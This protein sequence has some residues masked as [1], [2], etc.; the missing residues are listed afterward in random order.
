MLSPKG[1]EI[2]HNF[3]ETT[4]VLLAPNQDG[5]KPGQRCNHDTWSLVEF[6]TA[7]PSAWPT[8]LAKSS[9]GI[10]VTW[11]NYRSWDLSIQRRR[12]LTFKLSRI[13]QLRTLMRSVTLWT[14]RQISSVLLVLEI[15]FFQSSAKIHDHKV[16]IGT[17]IDLKTDSLQAPVWWSQTDKAHAE[18]FH[19]FAFSHQWIPPQGTWTSRHAA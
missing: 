11:S 1:L 4:I 5:T 15:L 3:Q 16:K 13:S 6:W 9:W 8:R 18:Q 10:L 14:L 17:K 2:R 19:C 12:D 7:L